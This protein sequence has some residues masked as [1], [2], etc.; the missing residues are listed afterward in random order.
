[1]GLFEGGVPLC[2]YYMARLLKLNL[3]KQQIKIL[4]DCCK[5]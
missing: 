1:M 5:N 4:T 2:I 3:E